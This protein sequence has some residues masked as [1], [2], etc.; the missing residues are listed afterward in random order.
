MPQV[1]NLV[2]GS[3]SL[4]SSM[5][6]LPPLTST[7]TA[8]SKRLGGTLYHVVTSGRRFRTPSERENATLLKAA[9]TTKAVGA[10]HFI[11]VKALKVTASGM[12]TLSIRNNRAPP[13]GAY[14]RVL[15]LAEGTPAPVGAV[16]A[17]EI[18][19]FF[20]PKTAPSAS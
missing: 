1:G 7:A 9:Q 19:E 10:T 12:Q 15:K 4:P 16:A 17:D 2:T 11:V 8:D 20:G 13:T 6:S 18:I 14:I 3:I 5:P